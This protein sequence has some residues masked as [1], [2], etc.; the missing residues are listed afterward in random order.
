MRLMEM[1]RTLAS[2]SAMDRLMGSLI[3]SFSGMNGGAPSDSCSERAP[4][5]RAF[6]NRV[7]FGGPISILNSSFSVSSSEVVEAVFPIG[8]NVFDGLV[9]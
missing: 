5:I 6:S 4:I 3:P 9:T 1:G 7:S 2:S 8:F